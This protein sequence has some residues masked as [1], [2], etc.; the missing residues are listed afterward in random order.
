MN[1]LVNPRFIAAIAIIAAMGIMFLW[2]SSTSNLDQAAQQRCRSMSVENEQY[3]CWAELLERK[4]WSE[5]LGNAFHLLTKLYVSEPNAPKLCH[6]L[7]HR[8][9]EIAYQKFGK[10][11][12]AARMP[13]AAFCHF[14][15]YHGFMEALVTNGG[16]AAEARAFCTVIESDL[17]G[18]IAPDAAPQ[19]FH[20]IGH[21]MVNGHEPGLWGNA[22]AMTSRALNLCEEVADTAARRYR[23]A[24]GVFNGLAI[25]YVRQ[26]YGLSMAGIDPEDPLRTCRGQKPEYRMPCYGNMQPVLTKLTGR[27]FSKI[28]SIIERLPDDNDAAST[29]WYHA[30]FH[31]A[32]RLGEMNLHDDILVCRSLREPLRLPCIQGLATGF[33]W[34]GLPGQEYES[35]VR[36]CNTNE[37]AGREQRACFTKIEELLPA[38]YPPQRIAEICRAIPLQY[39]STCKDTYKLQ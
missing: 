22:R 36:F 27:N 9:G 30:G 32:Q 8:I 6:L 17:Q 20:G 18:G 26:E 13:E 2:R 12:G 28:A 5:G 15:F 14:G 23:C 25:F 3:R 38:S 39:R 24:A 19:C 37:L 1:S 10:D 29:I 11:G 34:Y 4:I 33:L 21:G 35:A 16:N 31:M 7:T